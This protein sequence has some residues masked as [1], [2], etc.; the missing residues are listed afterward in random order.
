MIGVNM[1]F[2]ILIRLIL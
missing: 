2:D 1:N